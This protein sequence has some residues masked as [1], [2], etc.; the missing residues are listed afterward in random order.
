MSHYSTREKFCNICVTESNI[1]NYQAKYKRAK[2][3]SRSAA[4][5]FMNNFAKHKCQ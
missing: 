2:C 4:I 3:S 1:K 5:C